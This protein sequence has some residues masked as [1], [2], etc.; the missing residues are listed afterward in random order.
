MTSARFD[1]IELIIEPDVRPKG[2]LD[3]KQLDAAPGTFP[4]AMRVS[5]T[6]RVV[7]KETPSGFVAP[8]EAPLPPPTAPVP[9]VTGATGRRRPEP[10]P[11]RPISAEALLEA[12]EAAAG[13]TRTLAA[14][15]EAARAPMPVRPA[16]AA[17]GP[18]ALVS[19]PRQDRPDVDP[20]ELGEGFSAVWTLLKVLV[21]LLTLTALLGALG[22]WLVGPSLTAEQPVATAPSIPLTPPPPVE[23][24]PPEPLQPVG[25]EKSGPTEVSPPP[26]IEEPAPLR[27]PEEVGLEALRLV[28]RDA[29]TGGDVDVEEDAPGLMAK[30]ESLRA[31]ALAAWN[32]KPKD[33]KAARAALEELLAAKPDDGDATFRLGLIDH[34]EEK[35]VDAEARYRAAIGLS[36]DDPRPY[37]NLGLVLLARGDR[38]E[39]EDA[40]VR[41]LSAANGNDPNLNVNYGRLLEVKGSPELALQAYDRAL[42]ADPAH[43]PG[44]LARANLR[45]SLKQPDGARE[46]LDAVAKGGSALAPA[47]LDGLGI[48]AREG[49]RVEEAVG[50]HRRAL[51]LDPAY[52]PARVNLGLALL[53]Q[54]KADEAAAELVKAT[55]AA[56]RDARAWSALGVAKSRQADKDPNLLNDAKDAYETAL[57]LD[58]KD[59]LTLF[60]YAICAERFGNF[61]YAMAKYEEILKLDPKAWRAWGNLAR[62]YQRGNKPDKALAVLDRGLD[63]LPDSADLHYHR[64]A[65]LAA[66]KRER[67]ARASLRRFVELAR[68]DDPRLP[69]VKRGLEGS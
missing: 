59:T 29:R 42:R 6:G 36:P 33:L 4:P 13:D 14:L 62:L 5:S 8:L 45:R 20:D 43:G 16:A 23:P 68:P 34:T 3:L 30:I 24:K 63:A 61:L 46:D 47:A 49:S 26:L 51:E 55:K 50:L 67:D 44:R 39:A 60:N 1:G 9:Q 65:L 11:E 22:W 53:E 38:D 56:P 28:A 52:N 2:I 10:E 32:R 64:A 41:G 54:G 31:Q 21:Y 17:V 40:Y 35:M 25:V 57:K 27:D 69:D 37:N 18:S 15:D 48:L 12:A 66:E 19:S 7:P 58:G